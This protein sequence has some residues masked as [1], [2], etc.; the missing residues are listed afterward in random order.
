VLSW[1]PLTRWRLRFQYAHVQLDLTSKPGGTDVNGPN[2]AGNS[3]TN[4]LAVHSFL[5]LP[6]N[7]SLFT[8]VRYVDALPNQG[9]PSYAALDWSLAWRPTEKLRASLT[10]QNANDA[11]RAEFN[12]GRLIER[13]AYVRLAWTF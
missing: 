7:M 8:N 5:E 10:V 12:D 3:P 2:I 4:Q 9:V 11:R 6:W 13:S 1:Q